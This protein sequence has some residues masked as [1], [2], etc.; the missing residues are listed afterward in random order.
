MANFF[1][2]FFS[3]FSSKPKKSV[4]GIDVGSASLKVVQLRREK[5]RVILETYGEISL[6]PYAGTE[7]GRATKLNPDKLA[8]AL[9]DLM[10][11][12]NVSTIDSAVSIPMRSSMVSV[13]RLPKSSEKQISQMVPIE[14]RKYIPVP[15]S[16]VALDWFII[17]KNEDEEDKMISDEKGNKI[18]MT[19]VLTVA[20]HNDVLNAFSSFVS[21]S[22]LN[23]SFFEV[24]MFSTIR[25]VL[26]VND[27]NVPV[28][29]FDM[30]ASATKLYVVERGA[31]RESHIINK[32]SQDISLNLSKSLNI[33]VEAAERLK[34]NYGKNSPEQDKKITEVIELTMSSIFTQTNTVILNYGRK[35]QR[36][37]SKMIMVGGGCLLSGIQE[38]A[39]EKVGIDVATGNP[40][41]RTETP[42]FLEGVLTQ[43]GLAFSTAV[44]LALRK[45]QELE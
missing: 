30:G 2:N 10:K 38:K 14:A 17:P 3:I 44:G 18:P 26:D 20:I 12:A 29:I 13:I 43:T 37:I 41:E 25:S 45:L 40:F 22:E 6:G 19:E 21:I 34:R 11:E 5:G 31:V 27:S 36:T 33:S 32:G 28:L 7:I 15:I 9:R 8:E 4:L 1:D 35:Y 24:E 16:E 39:K 42:A 23:T